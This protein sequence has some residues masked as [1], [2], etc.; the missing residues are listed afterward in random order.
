MPEAFLKRWIASR[1]EKDVTLESVEADWESKYL[2]SLKWE[3]VDGALNKI[4][5]LEP[6]QNEIVDYVKDLLGKN[7]PKKDGEDD[8]ARDERLEQSARTIAKDRQ[9]VQ[10]II[11]RLYSKNS[12]ELFKEQ[13]KPEP[14]KVTIKEFSEKVK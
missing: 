8:K 7:E 13:L 5:T 11:D 12:F 4:K 9:N 2:P 3:M 10:Q 14:E 1:G 6:T